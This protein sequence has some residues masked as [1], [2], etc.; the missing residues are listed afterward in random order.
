MATEKGTPFRRVDID[1]ADKPDWFLA[2]S[3]TG[4]TP[5]L[6]VTDTTGREHVLFESAP[7]AE[8]LDETAPGSLLPADP[9]ERA[10]HRAWV[11]FASGILTEIAGCYA[12]RDRATYTAKANGLRRRFGQLEEALSAPW[13][14]GQRFGLVDAAF[15]PVFRYLDAFEALLDLH[16]A[17]DLAKIA[18]WRTGL[19][20]RPSVK[21]AV[22]PDYPRQLR[23]FLTAR[24]SHLAS[25]IPAG[26][27][28]L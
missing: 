13:F 20:R 5:L 9:L 21:A 6:R 25:L 26:N 10:R 22:A 3:P 28:R 19:T 12:A 2:I 16:L 18:E 27:D 4:K 15:G 17:S 14:A 11:E 1:L 8:Y 24:E 23:Q 7:I